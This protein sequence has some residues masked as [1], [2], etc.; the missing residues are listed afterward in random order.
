M[1]PK[2]HNHLTYIQSTLSNI[3]IIKSHIF[4]CN[5]HTQLTQFNNWG[6]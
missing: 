5:G 2:W 1:M 4:E 6:G 3:L